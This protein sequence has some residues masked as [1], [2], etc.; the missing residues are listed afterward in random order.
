MALAVILA[1]WLGRRGPAFEP[2]AHRTDEE[3]IGRAA[4]SLT[5][6]GEPVLVEVA[7][8]G[9][10]AVEAAL[11]RPEDAVPDRSVDP[12]DAKAPSSFSDAAALRRRLSAT[13][14]RWAVARLADAVRAAMGEPVATRGAWGLFAVEGTP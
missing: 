13:G 14:A 7:D 5:H 1:A 6:P 10:L 4:A 12:R 11:G 3:A 9:Y 2:F 8:Y